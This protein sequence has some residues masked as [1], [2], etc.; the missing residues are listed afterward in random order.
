[1]VYLCTLAVL[2]NVVDYC[3][4]WT[5]LT[6]SKTCFLYFFFFITEYY[7]LPTLLCSRYYR[8]LTK[9]LGIYVSKYL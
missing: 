4:K 8:V 3:S 2:L 1:M 7:T 5:I 6:C 9:Y